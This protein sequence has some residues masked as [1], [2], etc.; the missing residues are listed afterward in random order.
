MKDTYPPF[1]ESLLLKYLL[2]QT[3]EEERSRI[4]EW[5]FAGKENRLWLDQL[6]KVWV[7]SGQLKPEP[8]AVDV[9]AAW[10]TML[11][12]ISGTERSAQTRSLRY[13]WTAAAILL[14][15]FGIYFAAKTYL[16][17]PKMMELT[18]AGQ[19]MKD[20]LPDG[21][22][23]SLNRNTRLSFPEPFD[24][25][26]REVKLTGEAYF[27]VSHDP[28]K[29]FIVEAGKARVRVFGTSFNVKAYTGSG[30]EVS[31]EQ[32][33]VMLFTVNPST[34]DT[35]SLMLPA[36]TRGLLPEGSMQPVLAEE[37]QPDRLFWL[38]RTLEFRQTELSEVFN[39]ISGHFGVGIS[40]TDPAILRCRLSATFRDES[41]QTILEV[42][43]TSFELRLKNEG[44]NWLFDGKGCGK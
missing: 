40:A 36:G 43:A 41:L 13:V 12:R 1:E 21:S 35:L 8:V 9:D 32:G 20:T 33:L 7:E 2:G 37:S 28:A 16:V 24:R 25:K 17:P 44:K 3:G 6:E 30:V 18:T 31:V 38:D 5:L 22:R 39:V 29:P 26:K 4:E 42:I 23:I 15:S 27:E 11:D 34:R 19:I 10:G 14:V